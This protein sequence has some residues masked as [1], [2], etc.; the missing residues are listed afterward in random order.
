MGGARIEVE[1]HKPRDDGGITHPTGWVKPGVGGRTDGE[2]EDLLDSQ[3]SVAMDRI[4]LV[5]SK[6]AGPERRDPPGEVGEIE[7]NI[8]AVN[9]GHS[10]AVEESWC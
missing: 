10:G 7:N 5:G 8:A 3:G 4:N 9:F 2:E 6:E 1:I